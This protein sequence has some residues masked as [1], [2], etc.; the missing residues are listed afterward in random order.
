MASTKVT[1]VTGTAEVRRRDPLTPQQLH[2]DQHLTTEPQTPLQVNY[3]DGKCQCCPYGYHI[4]LDFLNFCKDLESGFTLRNLKRIQRTK[5]KL[6]KSMELMLDEQEGIAADP[7][8]APPDIIHSTEA[9]RLMH[10]INYER[11]ATHRILSQIDSSVNTTIS[12]IDGVKG[13]RYM[14]SDSD[15]MA[16]PYTPTHGA[17]YPADEHVTYPLSISGRTDSLTSLSSVSTMSSE[18]HMMQQGQFQPS[19][20]YQSSYKTTTKIFETPVLEMATA[21]M[22][23]YS[24]TSS[25]QLADQ[26]PEVIEPEVKAQLHSPSRP[27]P[28]SNNDPSV[29]E[30][31]ALNQQRIRELEEQVKTIPIL[32]VRISVL[33]EEKRLLNLQLKANKPST[34]P[35]TSSVGVGDGRVDVQEVIDKSIYPVRQFELPKSFSMDGDTTPQKS[36]VV[37]SPPATF[38]KPVKTATVGVGDHSVIE[39]YNIQPDLPTGYTTHNN[40]THTE[41][42]T[43]TLVEREK[44][45]KNIIQPPSLNLSFQH[46]STHDIMDRDPRTPTQPNFTINQIQRSTPK[47]LTRTVGVGDGNVNDGSGLHVHEKELRTVI[48]GQNSPV[49]KRNV[50]IDCRVPTRDV[51]V[52]FMCDEEKPTTRTIGVNVNYDTSNIMTSLDFKGETQLRLALRDVLQRSVRSVATNCNFKSSTTDSSTLTDSKSGVSVGCGDEE[53]RVDVEVRPA[54]V[55]KS[56]GMVAKPETVPKCVATEKDWIFDASTNTITPEQYHKACMTDKLKQIF[57]STNTDPPRRHTANIQTEHSMFVNT[58]QLKHSATNTEKQAGSSVFTSTDI[59]PRSDVGVNTTEKVTV[60]MSKSDAGVNTTEKVTV[61]MSKSDAGVN[62]TEKVTEL[63]QQSQSTVTKTSPPVLKSILKKTNSTIDKGVVESAVEEEPYSFSETTEI[64]TPMKVVQNLETVQHSSHQSKTSLHHNQTESMKTSSMEDGDNHFTSYELTRRSSAP[65]T[66]H[67]NTGRESTEYQSTGY[68]DLATRYSAADRV[69]P[70]KGEDSFQETVVEHYIITKDGTRLV[71]E[72]KTTTSS[73]SGVVTQYTNGDG[74]SHQSSYGDSGSFQSS[75]SESRSCQSSH[76]D[77]GSHQSSHGDT[78]TGSHQSSHGDT[79]SYQSSFGELRSHQSSVGD[80]GSYQSSHGDSWSRQTSHGDPRSHQSSLGDHSSVHS[81]STDDVPDHHSNGSSH[82]FKVTGGSKIERGHITVVTNPYK[83]VENLAQASALEESDYVDN[84]SV[85]RISKTSSEGNLYKDKK[86]AR[87]EKTKS[88][89]TIYDM[90]RAG[91]V[92]DFMPDDI[93]KYM[94]IDP[95]T[96][97]DSG[98]GEDLQHRFSGESSSSTLV[99]HLLSGLSA[100]HDAAMRSVSVSKTITTKTTSQSGDSVITCEK[101][102]VVTPDGKSITTITE[103]LKDG[104]TIVR[105][106]EDDGDEQSSVSQALDNMDTSRFTSLYT[107]H[108][109][110]N[111]TSS[112]SNL[113]KVAEH[114]DP[115]TL[116]YSESTITTVG[117]EGAQLKSYGSLDRKTGKLKSIMKQNSNDPDKKDKKTGIR[118]AETVIGGTGSSSEEDDDTSDSD[119]T[120][121]FEEGTYDSQQGEITYRCKDDEAVAQGLPGAQ[122]FDQNIRETYE[123]TEELKEACNVVATYLMDSTEVQTKQLNA[124]QNVLQQEWFQVSS[125][126]LSS[127][128]QVEDFLS[129]VN[130]ISKLLLKYIVNMTDANGNTAIHY[131]ISHSNFEIASLLLDSEVC[132]INKLNKAGYTP[133]MLAGL[134]SIQRYD[135]LEVVRRIFSTGDINARAAATQQTAL[136]LAASHGRVEMVKLLVEEGADINLQ[137]VDGSTALM[138]AC[139]HGSIEIVNF[140]LSQPNINATIT[141]N[142]NSSALTIAMEAGHKDLGVILYKHLNFSKP[143]SPGYHKKRKSSSSPTPSL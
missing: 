54:S 127:P 37:K 49:A 31:L 118:F 130:E 71:S 84:D 109:G 17:P 136:M 89:D 135:Q 110:I 115:G 121:S 1:F 113:L 75:Q 117:E 61:V 124:S 14:S 98:F 137:D 60:V 104:Q 125:L 134:A 65:A 64:I 78:D 36:P 116:S 93:R 50:G 86:A 87:K 112:D 58:D 48:I 40:Q 67:V 120:T 85:Q 53:Q 122:M 6:R 45:V 131:C 47:A 139:E 62:T 25:A 3:V 18:T 107:T 114:L 52:S 44:L 35:L 41:I 142:E 132:D 8:S 96:S 34:K 133:I 77:T 90:R 97:K 141:D 95:S 20:N 57:A 88:L 105:Q 38:P 56:F 99:S 59:I 72:E 138:C 4:D 46:T 128:H 33:K 80:S 30:T 29:R 9:G 66:E 82:T 69:S 63:F 39:P 28:P 10:M 15:D 126:K 102:T 70:T 91:S 16:S 43:T 5:R 101:Q 13:N 74:R 103:T 106:I 32:Q 27:R 100:E 94:S 143:S 123:L 2:S 129:S 21:E 24:T 51:G 22:K 19:Q 92:E 79:G 119:S 26:S 68:R 108:S 12:N 55:K 111:Q 140:L 42:H 76:G 81:Y 7:N 73:K 23:H 83:T 11:S